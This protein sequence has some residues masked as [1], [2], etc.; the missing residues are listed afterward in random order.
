MASILRVFAAATPL[1]LA[2]CVPP[3]GSSGAAEKI[4]IDM[5]QVSQDLEA[6]AN[7]R[8]LL[9]HQ[10]VGRNMLDGLA[11]L[12]AEAGVA[13]RIVEIDGTP[14]DDGP[15][16]FHSHIGK[17]GDPDSKCEVFGH[18]L[19]AF[20]EVKYDIAA[21]KFCYVDL[22]RDTPLETQA[23]LSRYEKLVD[24]VK[25]KRPDVKILHVTM[26]LMS[27]LP[28][29]RTTLKRMLGLSMPNDAD[30]ILR[31]AFND[32]LRARYADEPFFDLAAVEST[33]P[34]GSRSG[35]KHKGK[36]IYTLA[37]EYTNDG[38]HL[39]LPAQ[40]L[41]AAA[42]IRA[43]VRALDTPPATDQLTQTTS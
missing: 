30:N 26:P 40:R 39:I 24:D 14:P 27:D 5:N 37:A 33:L 17:N 6:L 18:L 1:M 12:A 34:D 42:F 41:A 10:S 13:L 4:V 11:S 16:L 22:G 29:R 2:G 38:G 21:M 35:F 15:G 20:S 7:A 28:G 23:M 19:T 8:I 9:G 31:N 32:A 43:V 25:T 3:H 36:F